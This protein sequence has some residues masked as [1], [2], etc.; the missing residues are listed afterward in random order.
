MIDLKQAAKEINKIIA[1]RQK[2]LSLT[3][4]EETHTY[5]MKNL[6][7]IIKSDWLSV[8]KV[9][10]RF[11][12]PFDA[13]AKSLSMCY[14][15]EDAQK[16]LLSEWTGKADYATNKGSRVHYELEKEEIKQYGNYKEVRQPI[17]T[18]DEQQTIDG[19]KMI[20]AGKEFLALMHKRGAILLDTEIVLGSDRLGYTGAPD[21]VWIMLNKESTGIVIVISDWKTNQPKNFITMPYSG[22]LHKPFADYDST[23]LQHYYL[24]LPLYGRLLLDM[25]LGSKW[26]NIKLAGCV[27]VLLKDDAT[28]EEYRVP[29]VFVDTILTMDLTKYVKK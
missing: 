25:L 22:K 17:F 1:D 11:Y 10:E 4:I 21:K 29:K 6:K 27:I 20:K 15:D 26:E 12:D 16:I 5:F 7:G 9:H 19:D 18:V 23:A 3:F 2:E 28:F 13:N 14:G 8:S 24:Q